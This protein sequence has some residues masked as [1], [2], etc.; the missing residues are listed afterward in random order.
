MKEFQKY[1]EK[2]HFRQQKCLYPLLFQEYIY[3]F[4]YDYG[5]NV[6]FEPVKKLIHYDKK[7]SL[8]LIKRLITR[9]YQPNYLMNSVVQNCNQNQIN[10]P[11]RFFYAH[12]FS[13]MISEGFSVVIEIPFSL[14]FRF[15]SSRNPKEI[16]KLQNLRS[17]HS[18][19]SFLEEKFLY[20][21]NVS[22][23]LIP[24]PIHFEI[25][26][27]ILQCWIQDIPSLHLLRFF[28]LDYSNWNSLI[29]SKRLVSIFSKE[30]KRLSRFLYNS[31]VS[32]YE[33]LLLFIRKQ[34]SCLR[35]T[36]FG[37]FLERIY[38]YGKIEHF[39]IVHQTF[40]QR[41][42]W[43]F[44]DP[45]MHY[46]RYQ[47]KAILAS[48]GTDLFMEKWKSYLVCFWQY[49][50]HFWSQSNRFHRNQFECYSLDF[51]GYSSNV[52][53][54]HLVVRSQI[55]EYSVLIDTI[56]KRFDNIV[57]VILLI[58]S[59]S[60]ASLCTVVGH[61]IS[62]PI[63]TDL[64][65]YDIIS[66]FGRIWKNLFHFYS[67]SSQ[68]RILYQMKYILR[69]SCAR[70]LARKHK[71]TVRTLLQSLGPRLLEEFLIEKK[72]KFFL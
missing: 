38:Y 4:A 42:I 57:P 21:N 52:K 53:R 70:T 59:L 36:S 17:I 58:R 61:P 26:V 1:L 50:F 44:T 56:I 34:S 46:V 14:G 63:W 22:D 2:Y 41:S 45:F 37:T 12:F 55:L 35:L 15:S 9:M 64:S 10:E 16:S 47:G 66:R 25:L 60:K 7:S 65:D 32:E 13:Q 3:V 23:I 20:L 29:I 6:P 24:Y 11:N 43:S 39:R 28:L 8:I 27:Q 49:Y 72:N 33:F 19:F 48:K 30:N 51:L 40:F 68:K 18:I 69:L 62:K 67:G 71:S 5:L 54:N 31:Y